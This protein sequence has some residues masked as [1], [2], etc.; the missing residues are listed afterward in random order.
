MA[1][2]A[3]IAN[4]TITDSQGFC[5]GSIQSILEIDERIEKQ[6]KKDI[7]FASQ[8]EITVISDGSTKSITHKIWCGQN[9]NSE[10]F[11]NQ[12]SGAVE[13][14]RLTRLCLNLGLIKE[15]ELTTIKDDKLPDLESLEG[16]K[17]KFKLEPSKKNQLFSVIDISTI[18]LVK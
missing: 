10:K 5:T 8:F 4:K 18:Q 1:L 14:N 3:K 15:S 2:K 7:K 13:Y 6:G 16:Q 17:I 11:T 12:E 9:I